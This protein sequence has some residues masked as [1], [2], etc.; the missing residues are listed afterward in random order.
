MWVLRRPLS[1]EIFLLHAYRLYF[2][3]CDG[4]LV[5]SSLWRTT[6]RGLLGGLFLC[7]D[8]SQAL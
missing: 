8:A 5:E 4:N 7:P 3:E 1:I 2:C 6:F